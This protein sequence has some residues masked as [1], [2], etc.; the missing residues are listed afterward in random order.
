M[1]AVLQRHFPKL[2]HLKGGC[3]AGY[4]EIVDANQSAIAKN[5][6]FVESAAWFSKA[7]ISLRR[8]F[9]DVDARR[10]EAGLKPVYGT[11]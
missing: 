3:V 7:S 10:A 8:L 9:R 1:A 5:K 6:R 2:L 11:Q 4:H